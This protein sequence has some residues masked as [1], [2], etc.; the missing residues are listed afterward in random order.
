MKNRIKDNIFVGFVEDNKDPKKLGRCKIRVHTVYD[1]IDTA[2]IPWAL[3]FKDLN[4]N[5]FNAPEVGKVVSV[6]FNNGNIY[7]PEFIYA[8]HYNI[9]L[10]NKLKALSDEDYPT[11]KAIHLDQSTQI[12]RSKS[13]GLK[14]DHEYTNVNLDKDGSI[15][16][17]LRD[18]NSKVNVGSPDSSQAAVL[19]TSWMAWMDKHMDWM[20]NFCKVLSF[21]SETGTGPYLGNLGN[22]LVIT[23]DMLKSITEFQTSIYTEYQSSRDPKFLSKHIWLVDNNEVKEQTRDYIN[24]EG[25]NWKSSETNNNLSKVSNPPYTPEARPE[26]GRSDI[27]DSTVP[28]DIMSNTISSEATVNTLHVSNYDNGKIPLD[29]MIK[30]TF[31]SKN[32]GG[33]AAYLMSDAS[34]GLDN[35]MNEFN[36]ASFTGKQKLTF[37]DGYRNLGRQ[38]AL[39]AKYGHGRAATPGTSNH[40]WGLAVDIYWG[41]RTSMNTQ[42]GVRPS[43]FKHPMYLWFLNNAGKY[44][45]FNPVKLRDDNGTDEWWHWEYHGKAEPTN[46]IADRYKGNFTSTDISNIKSSGGTYV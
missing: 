22:P 32:L 35:L 36:K 16:L 17:N 37:T 41:V 29:K 4:G 45:W 15:N 34:K 18:N 24:Q 43:A 25:D 46:I 31:L 10:E 28:G 39:Y 26:T 33:D 19:G 23:P 42:I 5:V 14:I 1:T 38:Q 12:Y 7:K 6:V 13:E 3:P 9:N 11:F 2:N 30:N 44:G 40:G 20:N 21:Q 27:K 8:E